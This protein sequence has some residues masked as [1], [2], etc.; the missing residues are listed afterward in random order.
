MQIIFRKSFQ[1]DFAR[2]S[3]KIQAQTEERVEFFLQDRFHPLLNFH[4]LKGEYEDCFS[5]NVNA[6]VR[7]IFRV[8][9]DTMHLIRV[10]SHSQLYG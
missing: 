3:S 4:A 10:G 6:D 1:K 2:C 8:S 7:V 5:I 9:A